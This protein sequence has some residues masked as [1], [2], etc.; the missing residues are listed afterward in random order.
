VLSMLR[1]AHAALPQGG[2]LLIAEPLSGTPGAEPI[3]DAYFGFYFL[4]MGQ[5]RSRTRAELS[6]LVEQA[7]FA[8]LSERRTALPMLVRVLTTKRIT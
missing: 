6:A 4:A 3:G 7:G 1:H 5:G 2:G 8:P